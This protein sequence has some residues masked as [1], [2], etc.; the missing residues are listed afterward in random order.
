MSFG[1]VW[2]W[3]AVASEPCQFPARTLTNGNSRRGQRANARSSSWRSPGPVD[4]RRPGYPAT[5]L[6]LVQLAGGPTVLRRH[7]RR[8]AD[9]SG[10]RRPVG[11]LGGGE[12]VAVLPGVEARRPQP[13]ADRLR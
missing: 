9:G 7:H 4:Y 1:V 12:R 2:C 13:D 10:L 5:A 11:G 3:E 8:A 6:E